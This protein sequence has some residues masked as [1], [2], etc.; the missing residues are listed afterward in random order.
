MK[1]NL[2]T[3]CSIICFS[4]AAKAQD[5]TKGTWYN[6]EKSAKVQFYMKEEKLFGKI[7]WLKE[8]L[9]NGKP[10]V[11]SKNPEKKLQATPLL[12]MVFLKNFTADGTSEWEDGKIYDPKNGKTYSSE[13]KIVS[14]T[15]INVRG[16]M[17]ISLIGRTSVF[18]KA[19]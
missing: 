8:P 18:T 12:G 19:D 2:L 13:I 5:I 16:Y 11:D 4:I 7:I 6:E 15:K 3:L 1:K 14:P 10:K 9:E 17:G